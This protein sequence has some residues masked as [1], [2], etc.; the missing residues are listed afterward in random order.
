[1]SQQKWAPVAGA[2]AVAARPN[3][4]LLPHSFE[5]PSWSVQFGPKRE[6]DQ[7]PPTGLFAKGIQAQEFKLFVLFICH[8][9]FDNDAILPLYVTK[10]PPR[11][12]SRSWV[13][14]RRQLRPQG[15]IHLRSFV[16]VAVFDCSVVRSG[17][18]REGCARCK[19]RSTDAGA[20]RG[21]PR[22]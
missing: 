21:R 5:L 8:P 17:A 1:M 11:G 19:G 15:R 16:V 20:R 10:L 2:R 13:G 6:H 3:V 4:L 7:S 9:I 22:S 18:V 12:V 14:I